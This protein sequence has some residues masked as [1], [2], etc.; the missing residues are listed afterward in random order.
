[1]TNKECYNLYLAFRLDENVDKKYQRIAGAMRE[2]LPLSTYNKSEFEDLIE[3]LMELSDDKL[4]SI[5]KGY[6][7]LFYKKF[8]KEYDSY[9]DLSLLVD[10]IYCIYYD[11]NQ[12]P[13]TFTF[14]SLSDSLCFIFRIHE[15]DNKEMEDYLY[16]LNGPLCN[17]IK[18]TYTNVDFSIY[19]DTGQFT[20]DVMMA[21]ANVILHLMNVYMCY[22]NDYNED[23]S[24][25]YR[26]INYAMKTITGKEMIK[27]YN[28][29]LLDEEA[30]NK[31]K[32]ILDYVYINNIEKEE[33]TKRYN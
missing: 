3:I 24:L 21:H 23:Y 29:L 30:L 31:Y 12:K 16:R 4:E 1:M 28:D 25:V 26:T 14:N 32:S 11:Y 8:Y 10:V 33:K 6:F 17:L 9:D 2:L 22:K 18:E 5:E 19:M 27:L 13:D 20:L 15:I 7:T